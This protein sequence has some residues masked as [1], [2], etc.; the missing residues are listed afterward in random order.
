MILINLLFVSKFSRNYVLNKF[1]KYFFSSSG[2]CAIR[3]WE[4]LL[5]KNRIN[6]LTKLYSE[7]DIFFDF[8]IWNLKLKQSM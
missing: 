3:F 7:L 2:F 6:I 5:R 1:D 4:K 8:D